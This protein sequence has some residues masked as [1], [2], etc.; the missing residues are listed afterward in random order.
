VSVTGIVAANFNQKRHLKD[1]K[2]TCSIE[3]VESSVKNATSI[4][5]KIPLGQYSVAQAKGGY[6]FSDSVENIRSSLSRV[7]ALKEQQEDRLK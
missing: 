7:V 5:V 6:L 3:R 1:S 2:E 4:G